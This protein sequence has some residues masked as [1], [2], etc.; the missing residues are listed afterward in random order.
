MS[1]IKKI[2]N[3]ED[4]SNY[5]CKTRLEH[6]LKKKCCGESCDDVEAVT[7]IEKLVKCMGNSGGGKRLVSLVGANIK[8]KKEVFENTEFI[9]NT[10][11]EFFTKIVKEDGSLGGDSGYEEIAFCN[12]AGNIARL[13]AFIYDRGSGEFDVDEFYI[14]V[15][16]G[17]TEKMLL[18]DKTNGVGTGGVFEINFKPDSQFEYNLSNKCFIDFILTIADVEGGVYE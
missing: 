10:L 13:S 12:F 14:E 6:L 17:K 2:I 3:G 4:V 1:L 5:G 18:W 11:N 8:F 7:D 15:W 16:T 9:S